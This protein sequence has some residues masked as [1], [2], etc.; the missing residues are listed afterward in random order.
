M[1]KITPILAVEEIEPSLEFW[2]ERLGF[3]TTV[4]VPHGDRL[5]FVILE[6]AGREVMLQTVESMEDDVP[7]VAP[8]AGQSVLYVQVED[9]DA[10]ERALQGV[11][12]AIPRRTTFYG[13]EEVFVRE[14]GGNVVGFAEFAEEETAH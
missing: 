2:V 1:E 4:E 11:E 10:I 7:A 6:R 3:E 8:P 5:G 13:A 12:L 9:L 14:P